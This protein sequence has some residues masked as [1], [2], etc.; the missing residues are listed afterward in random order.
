MMQWI[1]FSLITIFV[2]FVALGFSKKTWKLQKRQLLS[3]VGALWLCVGLIAVV[4]TG[5]TGILTTFGRVEEEK[6]EA[7]IHIKSP[8]QQVV[9][10]D[11]RTQKVSLALECFSSDI[12]EVAVVYSINYQIQKDNAQ[13]IYRTIGTD[14][15]NIVMIPRIQETVKSV[16]S[17]YDAEKLIENREVLSEQ[18][19]VILIESLGKSN[20]DVVSTSIENLDFSDAFT[21][22]VEDK[23]V[24]LQRK[25]KAKTEQEQKT[26]EEQELALRQQIIAT[27]DAEV[28]KTQ[29]A[30]DASVKG[31]QA[32][33]DLNVAKLQADA[34]AY[35][36][37]KD[38]EI[39]TAISATLTADLLKYYEIMAWDGKLPSYFVTGTDTV[40]PILGSTIPS[41]NP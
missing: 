38:A 23:Q 26:M 40:L 8:F 29:A 10:M 12:Q 21:Q 27:A 31:T 20:I 6:Y 3:L 2:L 14:Y 24:A 22:A 1:A 34:A 11:N 16:I 7:G 9:T 15:Y 36:G 13:K 17:N 4:P 5:H 19:T 37:E 25:L 41:A 39:N 18:I 28:K 33:A 32:T 35:A 30:A